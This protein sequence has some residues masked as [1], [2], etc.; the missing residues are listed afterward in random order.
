[1]PNRHPIFDYFDYDRTNNKSS[2]KI[3]DCKYQ[4]NGKHANNLCKHIESKHKDIRGELKRKKEQVAIA[5]NKVADNVKRQTAS[6]KIDRSEL[7]L[8]CLELTTVNGRPFS[9]LDDSGFQRILRP[10]ID[11]FRSKD[12][13]VPL[14]PKYIKLKANEMQ[15][16][17]KNRIKSEMKGKLLSF[18][19]DL[20]RHLQRC[21][22]GLN[23]QYY[24]DDKL[25]VRTLAMKRLLEQTYGIN[26]ANEMRDILE[27]FDVDVDDVYTVTSDN[28]TNVLS[29]ISSLQIFQEH[30][31]EN[32]L[33]SC[34]GEAINQNFVDY[35]LEIESSRI[36]QG[37]QLQF[38]HG[39][40]CCVHVLQL[41][42]GDILSVNPLK[43]IVSACRNLVVELK[44][45]NVFNLLVT[46]G[47][48]KPIL[49]CD[50]RWSS[51]H[52]MVCV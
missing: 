31:T 34:N 24:I 47:L 11:E 13:S 50:V 48:K 29:C 26:L 18:Q 16:I 49:D 28:E 36:E 17:V 41:A 43:D 15:E 12:I 9:M 8:A 40:R 30:R 14:N 5:K 42:M 33:A 25:V 39:V 35:L 10:I 22:F 7:L 46:K 1:M 19:I 2:C 27:S 45:P 44:T 52:G 4:A 3:S 38:L 6:V 32:Y 21:I 23:V 51:V 20:T 37:Q